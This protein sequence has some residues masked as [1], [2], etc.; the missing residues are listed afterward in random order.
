[1]R[2]L[3]CAFILL[4]GF[5]LAPLRADEQR[6]ALVIGNAHYKFGQLATGVNDAGLVAETLR[7]AGFEVTGGADLDQ[8]ALRHLLQDF[9]GKVQQAGPD[10]IVFVYLAGRGL[11]FAGENYFTPVDAVVQRE[12]DVP[13]ANVRLADYTRQIAAAPGRARIFVFDIARYPHFATEGHPFAGGLALVDP[14]PGTLYAFNAAPD[15]IAPDE[16]GP[17]GAYAMGLVEMMREGTSLDQMFADT[18]VRVNQLTAGAVVPWNASKIETPIYFFTRDADAPALANLASEQSKKLG[19]LPVA[20]AYTLAIER[21]TLDAYEEFL[22]AYP[23]DSLA[24]RVRALA[25]ARREALTWARAVAA[26][27]PEA[28]WT[29]MRRYR[30]GPH[31]VDARR[32]L[33]V[34]AAPLDPPPRFDPYDF[35]GLPPPHEEEY[36]VVDQPVL[37]FNDPSFPPPPPASNLPLRPVEF[38][39]LLP[40]QPGAPGALPSPAPIPLHDVKPVGAPGAI[41]EPAASHNAPPAAPSKTASDQSSAEPAKAEE[42]AKSSD[43]SSGAK[44]GKAKPEK[45]K[46]EKRKSEKNKPE[47]SKPEKSKHGQTKASKE[48]P[49]GKA[50]SKKET[51]PAAKPKSKRSHHRGR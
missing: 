7:E 48:G 20:A 30:F 22:A 26:N 47:R 12:A 13:I 5:S 6:L 14:E 32:R 40:P 9:A 18:R 19:G 51:K 31:F 50:K 38:E 28:Y 42:R 29:Y 3:F 39:H 25:A 46:P 2:V 21:D 33:A 43:E 23:R 8:N 27:T 10:A 49:H 15:S 45:A 37:I 36:L 17:Y 4:L 34:L 41:V 24:L 1:M 44:G 11:Q 16:P 35:G